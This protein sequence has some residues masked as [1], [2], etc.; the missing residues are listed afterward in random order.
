MDRLRIWS[1]FPAASYPRW[2]PLLT[3][4]TEATSTLGL[5]CSDFTHSTQAGSRFTYISTV[6]LPPGSVFLSLYDTRR[7]LMGTSFKRSTSPPSLVAKPRP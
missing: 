3:A 4:W 7:P 5:L 2:N 6:P 1:L